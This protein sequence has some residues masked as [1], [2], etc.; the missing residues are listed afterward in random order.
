[1]ISTLTVWIV[2]TVCVGFTMS[3]GLFASVFSVRPMHEGSESPLGPAGEATELLGTPHIVSIGRALNRFSQAVSGGCKLYMVKQLVSVGSVLIGIGLVLV[4]LYSASPA[5]RTRD[6]IFMCVSFVVGGAS[7]LCLGLLGTFISTAISPRVVVLAHREEG[8]DACFKAT[9]KGGTAIGLV[10]ATTT[11]LTLYGVCLLIGPVYSNTPRSLAHVMGA[12][13]MGAST[14]ALLVRLT[15]GVFAKAADLAADLSGKLG[16]GLDED[17]PRN[18]AVLCDCIGDHVSDVAGCSTDLVSSLVNAVL[19]SIVLGVQ[20]SPQIASDWQAALFPV[21]I[22]TTGIMSTVLAHGFIY[23]FQ[24]L[25]PDG[26]SPTLRSQLFIAALFV[27]VLNGIASV[28]FLPPEF[29]VTGVNGTVECSHFAVAFCINAGVVA[30]LAI[31]WSTEYFTASGG[32][33]VKSIAHATELGGAA[34]SIIQGMAVGYEST[35]IPTL[36]LAVLISTTVSLGNLYG[37]ALGAAGMVCCAAMAIGT[38]SF[39][40]IADTAGGY[41][42]LCRFPQYVR[43]RTDA[44][45]AAGNT[46]AA[47]GKGF[48]AASAASVGL[49]LTG[50]I[51]ARYGN[52]MS[53]IHVTVTMDLSL[54]NAEITCFL[55]IGAAI[56]LLFVSPIMQACSRSAKRLLIII[57]EQLLLN[58]DILDPNS[59]ALPDYHTVVVDATESS[60]REAL[61]PVL[62]CLAMP[63]C[64][65]SIFGIKAL[66]SLLVGTVLSGIQLAL[67]MCNTGGALDNAKKLCEADPLFA[68]GR[69]ASIVGDTVG[70]PM[71]DACGN[72]L[73]TLM[74]LQAIMSLVML[75]AFFAIANGKGLSAHV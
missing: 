37:L 12:F 54:L 60:L 47:V 9:L 65:G 6:G 27:L 26:V 53:E 40:A 23:C 1:M 71:K 11:L 44:L 18:P 57:E 13:G 41:A 73:N 32:R 24:I 50:A 61:V 35:F 3:S 51:Y 74:K 20:Q 25:D 52:M 17:D 46:T 42:G 21:S 62:L 70:D 36:I 43:A 69:E 55:L 72:A 14:T 30:G 58:P 22:M 7:N 59:D 33:P 31:G 48:S 2:F 28:Q 45:D 15:G 29:M 39:G 8:I 10:V 34:T 16:H 5:L 4:I 68:A 49:A 19:A 66:L 63:L 67:F 38:D 56:P 64:V 75:D